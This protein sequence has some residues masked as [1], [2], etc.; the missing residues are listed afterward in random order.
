MPTLRRLSPVALGLLLAAGCGRPAGDVPEIPTSNI[1]R[2]EYTNSFSRRGECLEYRGSGWT[3]QSAT[4]DCAGR[5]STITLGASCTYPTILGHCLLDPF[6]REL[7]YT[8]LPGDD[9][10]QCGPSQRGCEFFGGGFFIPDGICAGMTTT[11]GG[12][13]GGLPTFQPPVLECRQPRPTDTA[14][15]GRSTGGN[16]CTWSAISACTEE[17]RR[18]ADYGSCDVVRTQRPYQPKPP[19]TVT[20][21]GPDPRM[22]DPAYVAELA[23]VRSQ[24]ESC[25]CVCCHSNQLAPDGP[26]NWYVEAPGNWMDTFYNAGLALGAGWIDSTSFGEYPAEQNNGFTRNISGVPSTDGARMARFFQ[27]ELENRGR[28]REDFAG[29]V[30][31]GGPIY[32]QSIYTPR[33]CAE[34]VGVTADNSIQWT[35]GNARYVYVLE[36]GSANPGVPPNLDTPRGTLWRLDVPYT[37]TPL[38]SGITYGMAPEGTMQRIPAA[39]SAPALVN[40]RRY[41]LY[42]LADVGLPVTRCTF[43]YPAAR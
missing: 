36:E 40:G 3:E 37:G 34:G 7:K 24:V 17:G 42:V 14:G 23:W 26:S 28:R 19:A 33:A 20:R 18:F 9:P 29:A 5:D 12:G 2:C 35:G 13:G 22:S 10:A 27:R 32:D 6:S 30:P 31:F 25:A 38:S 15:P 41:Y 1:G 39:G 21:T 16:V 43:A 8:T 4:R 11:D